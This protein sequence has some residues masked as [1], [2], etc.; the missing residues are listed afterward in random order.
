MV[1]KAVAVCLFIILCILIT[2]CISQNRETFKNANPHGPTI[3]LIIPCIPEDMNTLANNL[4]PTI[5]QQTLYPSEIII[6]LSE[7]PTLEGRQFQERL[8]VSTKIPL[9]VTTTPTKAWAGENRNRGVL[10]AKSEY[11]S[12]MDADDS[13]HPQRIEL[14]SKILSQY[15]VDGVLHTYSLY[16]RRINISKGLKKIIL[17]DR[18]YNYHRK[19]KD[20]LALF[21][22]PRIHHGH[23]TFRRDLWGRIKFSTLP[24]GQDALF[25]REAIEETKNIII[26]PL[27]LSIYYPRPTSFG[28][29]RDQEITILKDF[30]IRHPS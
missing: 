14:L 25:V 28:L 22:H 5:N 17:P 16:P 4:L 12:F 3:S 26:I 13:M 6:A 1:L 24:R 18:V 21:I 9:Y 20:S 29:P 23:G 8:R 19:T 27:D 7:T 11:V 2:L 30:F 15:Q 10:E